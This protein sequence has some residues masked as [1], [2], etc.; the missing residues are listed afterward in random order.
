V[1]KDDDWETPVTDP[2]PLSNPW[3]TLLAAVA[4]W[5]EWRWFVRYLPVVYGV[6]TMVLTVAFY[7]LFRWLRRSLQR[8]HR[9]RWSWAMPL[10]VYVV[11]AGFSSA[12][13]AMM[14]VIYVSD[15]M[16][17]PFL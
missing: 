10:P 8:H 11:I 13:F 4:L 1:A 16:G 15:L 6:A 7:E 17:V 12:I 5:L 2:P 9:R 14:I 3:G